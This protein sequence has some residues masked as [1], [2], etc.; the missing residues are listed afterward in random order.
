[1]DVLISGLNWLGD[2]VMAMPAL[3]LARE[4][5]SDWHIT[6]LVKPRMMPLWDLHPAID[7]V[8]ALDPGI[9][10]AF[11]TGNRLRGQ[12]FDEVYVLPNSFRSAFVP[13]LGRIPRRVGM[14]GHDRALLLTELRTPG[15]D[16]SRR[17]QSWEYVSV[18]GVRDVEAVDS[19]VGAVPGFPGLTPREDD[20]QG[21]RERVGGERPVVGLV[22]GAA[23]GPAKRWGEERFTEV[24]RRFVDEGADVLVLG[25]AAEAEA[26]ARIAAGAGALANSLAGR[27]SLQ[28]LVAW[29]SLCDVVVTNDSGGMHLAAATGTPV[30]A[31]FGITDPATTGPIARA[32]RIIRAEGFDVSRDIPRSSARATEALA[33]IEPGT[34]FSAARGIMRR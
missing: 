2:S 13:F 24:G 9:G 8:L 27:T 28:E 15:P 31:V 18:L 29:L 16:T 17:H 21:C 33:S 4:R 14:A 34:V 22:P 32:C 3:Q 11:A 1:M 26:C 30:V 5:C 10:G 12:S 23:R 25:T 19:E 7:S 20:V 6:M